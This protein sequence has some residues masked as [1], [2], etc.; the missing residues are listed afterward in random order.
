MLKCQ[1]L[2]KA[3]NYDIATSL[4]YFLPDN[5]LLTLE[6]DDNDTLDLVSDELLLIIPP[7]TIILYMI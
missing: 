2:L 3:Q 4:R 6:D 5:C 7:Q 1:H